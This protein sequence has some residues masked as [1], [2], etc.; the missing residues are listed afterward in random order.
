VNHQYIYI[1]NGNIAQP[2]IGDIRV[3][4]SV[5]KPGTNVVLF[6]E[7]DENFIIP[8]VFKKSSSQYF[9]RAF[10]TSKEDAINLLLE[11]YRN[12]L[13]NYRLLGA[14][15]MWIGL[16]VIFKPLVVFFDFLPFLG[17]LSG[18]MLGFISLLVSLMLSAVTILISML[19]HN[20]F[21]LIGF[22]V[23]LAAALFSW[24]KSKGLAPKA[25]G[26]RS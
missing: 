25:K 24:K 19:F 9:Y 4:Y 18:F 7:L 6:G 22:L 16:R 13:W 15:L 8:H 21:V 3:S 26:A 2:Q 17:K 5:L 12:S 14:L 20:V 10:D 1:G 11:E 23:L